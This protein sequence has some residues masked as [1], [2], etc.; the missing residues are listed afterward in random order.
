MFY[1]NFGKPKIPEIM[2][3]PHKNQTRTLEFSKEI[4]A[5]WLR[6][7]DS[8]QIEGRTVVIN[9][10]SKPFTVNAKSYKKIWPRNSTILENVTILDVDQV[11]V[12]SLHLIYR[13]RPLLLRFFLRI[14]EVALQGFPVAVAH[15]VLA[16]LDDIHRVVE[17]FLLVA[18]V[19][20]R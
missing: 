18:A 20:A 7:F 12:G 17:N 13:G 14:V 5:I 1:N 16:A 6:N 19:G 15:V 10:G 2:A 11:Q 3:E 4:K 8:Y 9:L